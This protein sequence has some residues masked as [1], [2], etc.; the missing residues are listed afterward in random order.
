MRPNESRFSDLSQVVIIRAAPAL[1]F[2]ALTQPCAH[3]IAD[4]CDSPPVHEHHSSDA[5]LLLLQVNCNDDLG[6]VV[7]RW[8]GSYK[9]GVSPTEWGG[10][11]DILRRWASSNCGPVRYG[12]CWVFASVL[13]TGD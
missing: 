1:T 12:Q 4:V 3:Y 10:S 8:Q 9:D 6:V 11:G 7:G 13:C 2:Y 5:S